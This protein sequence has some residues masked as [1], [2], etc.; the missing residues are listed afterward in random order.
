MENQHKYNR[1]TKR[2]MMDGQE[3]IV[4]A[5][6]NSEQCMIHN[7]SGAGCATCP[8]LGGMIQQLCAFEDVYTQTQS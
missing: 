6:Y 3:C 4:C 1:L 2:M 8:L 7:Q 5:A